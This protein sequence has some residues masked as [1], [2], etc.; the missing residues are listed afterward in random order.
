[1]PV[2]SNKCLHRFF[3]LSFCLRD[4]QQIGFP[5]QIKM[6]TRKSFTKMISRKQINKKLKW[7]RSSCSAFGDDDDEEEYNTD[8]ETAMAIITV[9]MVVRN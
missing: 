1:M 6:K 4:D 5:L 9:L 3:F 2:A 8:T 7:K